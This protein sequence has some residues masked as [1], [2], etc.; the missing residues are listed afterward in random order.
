MPMHVLTLAQGLGDNMVAQ[1]TNA[2]FEWL[3][4]KAKM[5]RR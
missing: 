1:L 4:M 3:P 2:L 5:L